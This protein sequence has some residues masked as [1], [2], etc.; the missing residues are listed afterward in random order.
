MKVIG[1]A[2]AVIIVLASIASSDS[3]GSRG[4]IGGLLVAG[5]TGLIFWIAGV[6]VTALGQFLRIG[7]HCRK[8]VT[9][10]E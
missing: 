4:L 3:L 10:S 1:A 9:V 8:H 2:I 6:L 5:I 7:G